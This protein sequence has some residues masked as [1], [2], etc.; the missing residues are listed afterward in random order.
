[1]GLSRCQTFRSRISEQVVVSISLTLQQSIIETRIE[2]QS[3]SPS[4]D[5]LGSIILVKLAILAI[6]FDR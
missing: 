1:M 4:V 5:C 6:E 3:F 2:F